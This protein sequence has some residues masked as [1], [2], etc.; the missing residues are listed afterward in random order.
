MICLASLFTTLKYYPSQ[1]ALFQERLLRYARTVPLPTDS[2]LVFEYVSVMRSKTGFDWV[3]AAEFLVD[4]EAG[5]VEERVLR[6]DVPLRSA[7]PVSPVHE[8][9][10]PGSYAP[11][12]R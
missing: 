1:D 3:P 9:V 11:A 5:T 4:V 8:G 7:D 10:V 2:R 12:G 6:S